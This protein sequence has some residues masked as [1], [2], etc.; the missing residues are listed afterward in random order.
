MLKE[1]FRHKLIGWGGSGWTG[2]SERGGGSGWWG[3]RGW[4]GGS[5]SLQIL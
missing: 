4:E 3:G 5:C 1:E 2:G